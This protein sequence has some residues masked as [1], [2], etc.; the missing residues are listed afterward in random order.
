MTEHEFAE[1]L[2]RELARR[3]FHFDP[4]DVRRFVAQE[5]AGIQQDPD[6]WGWGHRFIIRGH[7]ETDAP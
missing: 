2:R 6:P 4:A 3:G 7:P 1:A 5:W